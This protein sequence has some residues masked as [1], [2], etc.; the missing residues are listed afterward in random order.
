MAQSRVLVY[1]TGWDYNAGKRSIRYVWL[2]IAVATVTFAI[3]C[4]QDSR[5]SASYFAAYE[6]FDLGTRAEFSGYQE[7]VGSYLRQKASGAN[8]Q[9]CVIGLTR[10]PRDTEAVWIIWR[11]GYRLI[12]WF[13]GETNL[14]LSSRNL[15]LTKDVVPTDADV[16]S[17]T[18][19]VSRAWVDE[20][21]RLCED[22]GRRVKIG[23]RPA[24]RVH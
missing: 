18:Y 11:K 12:R 8:T 19:L 9:A 20:L 13:A 5:S 21:E 22:H 10:G 3:A 2:C 6:P 15:S 17:S 23:R 14:D 16:G 1:H 7:V 4:V 24:S